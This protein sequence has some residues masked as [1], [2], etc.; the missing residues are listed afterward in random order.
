[1]VAETGIGSSLNDAQINEY[2]AQVIEEIK[3]KRTER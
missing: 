1:M 2:L 3:D